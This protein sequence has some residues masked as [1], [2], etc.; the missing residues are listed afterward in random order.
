M[1]SAVPLLLQFVLPALI[2]GGSQILGAGIGA[3]GARRENERQSAANAQLGQFINSFLTGPLA[4]QTQF[5]F[6]DLGPRPVFNPSLPSLPGVIGDPA[7]GG[8]S[9][10]GGATTSP[11][12]PAGATTNPVGPQTG[13]LG[14]PRSKDSIPVNPSQQASTGGSQAS[15]FAQSR[16]LGPGGPIG[17]ATTSPVGPGGGLG[18][19]GPAGGPTTNPVGP[20]G[21]LGPGGPIGGPTT[22]PVGPGGSP[23]GGGLPTFAPI[24]LPN[25]DTRPDVGELPPLQLEQALGLEGAA[26]Q[27]LTQ[28][29]R[30][31]QAQLAARGLGGSGLELAQQNAL[32]GNVLSSLAGQINQDQIARA[33]LIDQSNLSRAALMEQ[34]RSG[35]FGRDLGAQQL[36]EQLRSGGF[37][38]QLGAGQFLAQQRQNEFGNQFSL[39]QFLEQQRQNQF[40]NELAQNQLALQDVLTRL[41]LGANLVSNPALGFVNQQGVPVNQ[42]GGGK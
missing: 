35:Q 7:R 19:G 34:L 22:N 8:L 15:L 42:G 1:A 25:I 23:G 9:G 6:S 30:G 12:G 37:A 36:F 39:A 3:R 13:D 21:G 40:S 27:A 29:S 18:P 26:S 33:G 32:T 2:A 10:F 24:D 31:L 4:Q 16:G 5:S 38:R 14:R 28:G 20:G 11:V 17:G 41:G